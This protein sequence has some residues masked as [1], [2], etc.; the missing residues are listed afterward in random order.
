VDLNKL[1]YDVINRICER[2]LY[3]STQ[4][5][6]MA[7]SRKDKAKG[8]PKV[9]GHPAACSSYLHIAAALHLVVKSGFDHIAVKPHAAPMD[10]VFNYFMDL[11][12]DNNFERMP[13]DMAKI[14][15]TGLRK[16]SQNGE[17]VFQSYHSAYDPDHHNFLPSG[18]VGIPPVNLGYLA[19]AYRLVSDHGYEAPQDAH[20]W[21]VMGD[22][23]YR[24]GS[25]QEA[26]PDFSE[27][28]LGNI[29]WIVDY[30]RQSLDGHRI[31][32]KEIMDGTDNER[33]ARTAKASGWDV[34]QVRHGKF[35]QSVFKKDGGKE[36]KTYFEDQLDDF[37]L[38]TL[39]RAEDMEKV[40]KEMLDDNKKL[41][42]ILKQLSDDELKQCIRDMGG[43]D[44]HAIAEAMI[45]SKK[46]KRRPCLIIIHT[47]K[48]WG[49]E[50]AAAQANHNTLPNKKEVEALREYHK[51]PADDPFQRFPEKSEE[52]KFL[53]KRGD[54]LYD[55]ILVQ[56]GLRQQNADYFAMNLEK[57]GAI[58]DSL[59]VNY[60]LASYPHTQWMLGQLTSKL[61]RI[62]NT[63]LDES[64]L[65]EKQ[66][67]L[68]EAEKAW[69]L[70]SEL[71]VSMAP[72]VGTSTNLNPSMDGQ[73]YDPEMIETDLEKEFNLK[74]TKSPD[75]IPS[76]DK[77]HK[78]IR[79]EIEECN[80]TSCVGSYGRIRDVL[81]IPVVPIMTIYDFFVKRALDQ[82]FYNLY[83]KSSF[84]MIGTPAGVTL[85]P[86]G[87]QHGWKSDIQ[88]PNQ[89]TWEPYFCQELDW[90]LADSIRRHVLNDNEGRTG[91]HIRTVTRGADQKEMMKRLKT[92]ARFKAQDITLC[93]K[94]YI[95]E[96]ATPE[97]Q[98]EAVSDD[99]ILQTMK[100]ETLAGCYTLVNYEGYAGYVPG[101]NVVNIFS[102]G[103]TTTEAL[104]ASDMLLQKGIY[105]NVHVVTSSDLLCG[106]QA[107]ED[108]YH[109]LKNGLGIDTKL[110]ILPQAMANNAGELV[111]VAGRKIPVVSVHDGEAGLLDNL[112]S[113]LG[114]RHECLA[115]RK[116]S[117]CGRPEEIYRFHE[118]DEHA[119][120]EAAGK[121][122]SETA[123]EGIEI[124]RSVLEQ[125]SAHDNNI[126]NWRELWPEVIKN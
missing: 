114:V 67:P 27:R 36:L 73:I 18:T 118:I 29:T 86:E 91:V 63:P 66:K 117:K 24:E 35:R 93:H 115:V 64:E 99:Q 54:K 23:E 30:N 42:K 104:K 50:S 102:M 92:Q 58:P 116:H 126:A 59:D 17:P 60:K 16:Y 70:I 105:A 74:D 75:L 84:I 80:A 52:T 53:K 32:N 8:D 13:E 46:D 5:I 21:A 41:D 110:H 125:A 11:L 94:D 61:N 45:E 85:S 34:I 49:L 20:F 33:I 37:E 76:E 87:A 96:G 107:H 98:V 69:K 6:Y 1:N 39:L 90:I 121:A 78:F 124:H 97:T 111:S 77:A 83:W 31:T 65:K 106:I 9:G 82:H 113:V 22:A 122:L 57:F 12:L 88:I 100:E 44:V 15:M 47:I 56:E 43:H 48:G 38:Q 112:G 108:N 2:A 62:A 51:I 101:D 26:L 14:A 7:N 109:H 71:V 28:E 10:H 81:G 55:D 120:V 123:M 95:L 72:D 68:T 103:A 19:H 79:F 40:R 3:F 89:I 119:I 4:M 25:L